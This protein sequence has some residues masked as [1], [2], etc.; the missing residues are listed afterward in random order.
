MAYIDN[1]VCSAQVEAHAK[2]T[3]S[4]GPPKAVATL[5]PKVVY[6]GV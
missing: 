6:L 1:H 5:G 3:Q 4:V 2:V